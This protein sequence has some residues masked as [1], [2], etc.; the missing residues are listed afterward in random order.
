MMESK[1]KEYEEN[2]LMRRKKLAALYNNEIE[3]WRKEVL[4]KVET[5]EDRKARWAFTTIIFIKT[6]I[7]IFSN[8]LF[9]LESWSAPML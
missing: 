2:L 4:S 7:Y 8:R 1:R 5:Q 9:I 6:Y 3:Q